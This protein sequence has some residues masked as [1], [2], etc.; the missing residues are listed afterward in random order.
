MN[1]KLAMKV[2]RRRVNPCS[3]LW[4]EEKRHLTL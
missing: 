3:G 4:L 2:L 1:G